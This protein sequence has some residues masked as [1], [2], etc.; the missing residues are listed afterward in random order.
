MVNDGIVGVLI[1]DDN[2]DEGAGTMDGDELAWVGIKEPIVVDVE[3][4]GDNII[5]AS[6]GDV[7]S[8]VAPCTG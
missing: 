4:N 7:N 1:P 3:A 5:P 6:C 2:V 8:R